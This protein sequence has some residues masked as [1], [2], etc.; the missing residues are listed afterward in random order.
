M[1]GSAITLNHT[2]TPKYVQG[3]KAHPA[4]TS[5]PTASPTTP[6]YKTLDAEIPKHYT[7][8]LGA[9]KFAEDRLFDKLSLDFEPGRPLH[10]SY[11]LKS[12]KGVI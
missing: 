9:S 7:L 1:T 2:R 3:L 10:M 5:K 6:Y 11:S 4:I 8:N 12:L